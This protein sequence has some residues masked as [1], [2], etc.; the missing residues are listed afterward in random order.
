MYLFQPIHIC[1]YFSFLTIH[2]SILNV[3]ILFLCYIFNI[4]FYI[5]ILNVEKKKRLYSYSSY[6]LTG[7]DE[8][9]FAN[10]ALSYGSPAL[11]SKATNGIQPAIIF[12]KNNKDWTVT[13]DYYLRSNFVRNTW[14]NPT[15]RIAAK[16]ALWSTNGLKIPLK[17]LDALAALHAPRQ[18]T[19]STILNNVQPANLRGMKWLQITKAGQH[20]GAVVFSLRSAFEISFTNNYVF[21]IT[22]IIYRV[23]TN[24]DNAV[25]AAFQPVT[26]KLMADGTV[27][28]VRNP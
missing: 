16:L 6:S 14:I 27:Q 4:C 22:P 11:L 9:E 13:I 19:V 5:H 28:N 26:V 20:Q 25:L 12:Q 24:L 17:S 8:N 2:A 3:H 10:F 23:D 7:Q 15:N 21:Q 1:I 18:T